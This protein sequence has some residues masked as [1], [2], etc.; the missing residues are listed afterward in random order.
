M[1]FIGQAVLGRSVLDALQRRD[2]AV[3]VIRLWEETNSPPPPTEL[4]VEVCIDA[5]RYGN[6]ARFVRF[7]EHNPNLQRVNVFG[8]PHVRLDECA[9]VCVRF[10]DIFLRCL[11][12]DCLLGF[13]RCVL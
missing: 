12:V 6:A 5:R 8:G 1:E 2:P 13:A 7:S 11:S 10:V 4:D 9:R 3:C